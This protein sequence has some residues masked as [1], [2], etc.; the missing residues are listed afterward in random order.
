MLLLCT[1]SAT[2]VHRVRRL[3]TPALRT[4]RA[5][6]TLCTQLV[7][8]G[9]LNVSGCGECC[10]ALRRASPAIA[11][12]KG[13]SN[14]LFDCGEDTQRQLLRQA[15]VRPGKVDRV[16]ITRASAETSFGLPGALCGLCTDPRLLITSPW[17]I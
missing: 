15:L 9:S 11:L 8:L 5:R 13:K 16:F 17:S 7:S 10:G 14:F 6:I 2:E 4:G 1:C 12:R 3:R